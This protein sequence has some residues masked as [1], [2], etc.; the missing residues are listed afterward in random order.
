[1]AF[2]LGM[3]GV[4][5]YKTGGIAGGGSWTA[6][7]NIRDLTLGLTTG[8]ADMTTRANNGWRA[9]IATLREATINWD[10][11]WDTADA[12]FTAIKTAFLTNA[13]IGL[14]IYDGSAEGSQGLQADVMITGFERD[15][16]LEEGMKVSVTA[17]IAY[18]ATAPTW[19]TVPAP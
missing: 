5:N 10:M 1:M 17:V 12:G 14:Q 13:V 11:V 15:E 18:S 4:T 16:S 19:E 3:Q 8:V 7:T 6:L 9:Q 2:R